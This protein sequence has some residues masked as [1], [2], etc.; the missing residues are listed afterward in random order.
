MSDFSQYVFRRPR[1]PTTGLMGYP[2]SVRR[3]APQS[4]GPLEAALVDLSR[5]GFR[6]RS[7]EPLEIGESVSIE[8]FEESSKL[9]VSLAGVVR[10]RLE[11]GDGGW[12]AGCQAKRQLDW[13]TLG[14]L[15]L[16]RVLLADGS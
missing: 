11:D 14:E 7:L 4:P 6:V 12:L 13:E 10:W 3:S 1:H 5:D 8:I 9:S 15:F 16:N 2:V